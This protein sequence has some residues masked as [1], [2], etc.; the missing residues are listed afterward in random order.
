MR[1]GLSWDSSAERAP[2]SWGVSLAPGPVGAQGPGSGGA[3]LSGGAGGRGSS[4]TRHGRGF[5]SGETKRLEGPR[6]PVSASCWSSLR[7]GLQPLPLGSF[8]YFIF[9]LI[10]Q[11]CLLVFFFKK[12]VGR[13][14]ASAGGAALCYMRE[15]GLAS[16]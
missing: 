14:A 8:I 2:G 3:V 1:P 12:H 4:P 10:C 11:V 16:S 15:G 7:H 13:G 6:R 5:H 9:S